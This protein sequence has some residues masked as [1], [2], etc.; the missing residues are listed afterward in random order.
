MTLS[1]K[2]SGQKTRQLNINN[3]EKLQTV[4]K[5]DTRET[6]Q[7]RWSLNYTELKRS[8]HSVVHSVSE[9]TTSPLDHNQRFHEEVHKTT[10]KRVSSW[11]S[12]QQKVQQVG[13]FL[14]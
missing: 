2:P 1:R 5:R 13:P 9:P 14:K 6:R 10:E 8:A 4:E 12:A 3:K 7:S 11:T